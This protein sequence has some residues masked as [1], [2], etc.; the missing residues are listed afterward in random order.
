MFKPPTH[1][2]RPLSLLCPDV[3]RQAL[4]PFALSLKMWHWLAARPRPPILLDLLSVP[5]ARAG[6]PETGPA[7][8]FC[9]GR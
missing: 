4:V 8:L 7:S 9:T 1:L 5:L 6:D 2:F 3:G